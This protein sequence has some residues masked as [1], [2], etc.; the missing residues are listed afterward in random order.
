MSGIKTP[1]E[2]GRGM[3]EWYVR[4]G[5]DPIPN[6]TDGRNPLHFFDKGHHRVLSQDSLGNVRNDING[7]YILVRG[8]RLE[9]SPVRSAFAGNVQIPDGFVE[10]P[11]IDIL[12]HFSTS[13]GRNIVKMHT[14]LERYHRDC[15]TYLTNRRDGVNI[16]RPRRP[17]VKSLNLDTPSEFERFLHP[18][19]SFHCDRLRLQFD[20]LVKDCEFGNNA[21]FQT[22]NLLALPNLL[23]GN[24]VDQAAIDRWN[25][26]QNGAIFV[27]IPGF[28]M[29]NA[30]NAPQYQQQVQ[31]YP[32]VPFP[33]GVQVL[34][35][36][37]RVLTPR[38]IDER[39]LDRCKMGLNTKWNRT[40]LFMEPWMDA[41]RVCNPFVSPEYRQAFTVAQDGFAARHAEF[42]REMVRKRRD[43]GRR[44]RD[45]AAYRNEMKSV[46]MLDNDRSPVNEYVERP[47]IEHFT[48][49]W[50]QFAFGL[51]Q[52]MKNYEFLPIQVDRN[53]VAPPGFVPI[54][55]A[56]APNPQ[57]LESSRSMFLI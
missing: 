39:M 50:R 30:G 11:E 17:T 7:D 2:V 35:Q 49:E 33:G 13:Y 10:V 55:A 19:R 44:W 43:H 24:P 47:Q 29:Y 53:F 6:D 40:F 57:Q 41:A 27:R 22:L 8:V 21:V 23:N 25:I 46:F 15:V 4:K 36:A 3:G 26:A 9:M 51:R 14:V 1:E 37:A 20:Q 42:K 54:Y 31:P 45:Y 16:G 28:R 18:L 56:N 38:Q 48:N 32:L 52:E 12:T 5:N 34:Q